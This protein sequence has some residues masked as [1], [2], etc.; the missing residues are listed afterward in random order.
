MCNIIKGLIVLAALAFV[1]AVFEALLHFNLLGIEPEGF[2]RACNNLALIAIALAV[3][4]KKEPTG[5]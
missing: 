2:S 1:V 5:S 4:C 3:C